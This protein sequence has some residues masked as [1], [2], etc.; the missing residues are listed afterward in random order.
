MILPT[1]WESI[2][3]QD[4]VYFQEGPGLRKWQF[5]DSGIP[6]LNIRTFNKGRI[7]KTKCQFVKLEE[8]T[9]KYEHFLLDAGD[10]VVSSS[11]TLGKLVVIKEQDLPL[12][13]NT[14]VIRY[15]S[16]YPEHLSQSFLKFYLQSEH[17]F[18]QIDTSKTGTAILNYGPS[19]LKQMRMLVP[20]SNEQ[21]R[22][23]AKLE[24]LFS[25]LDACR[26]RLEQVPR[27]LKQFRQSIL[28]AACSGKLTA[29]WRGGNPNVND[30]SSFPVVTAKIKAQF[31]LETFE[32]YQLPAT[33]SWKS[34]WQVAEIKSNLVNPTNFPKHLLIAPDNIEPES[35][36][37]V[38]VRTVAE[39]APISAKHFFNEGQI[40][41]SKI[42][43]Y[44][45]KL[46]VAEHD[47][48]CS[49]DMYPISAMINAHY[50]K[51]FM[52]SSYFVDKA[53]NIGTRT[54]L[55]KINQEELNSLPVAVPPI[56]EQE[57]IVRRVEALFKIADAVEDHYRK[58]QEQLDKL[59]QAILAKA[60]R[61]E[62]VPQDPKDEPASVLLE[63][64][65][66]EKSETVKPAKA[67]R[68]PASKAKKAAQG[69]LSY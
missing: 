36:R 5:G 11:G 46:I 51:W 40:V 20:P 59:P 64:I 41:Y 29:D 31:D 52:L 33:W 67:K 18:Q 54:L 17:F 34:F 53:S 61:G 68:Q 58:A 2:P 6:F 43:P 63:H 55:P 42:R 24:E 13:L 8:F 27:L 28:A 44:L 50:L 12:M 48:L 57:E 30:E 37:L 38:N 62:L 16:L 39:I 56:E 65:R 26:Q 47:G 10:I 4:C 32:K 49:A 45:S 69:E 15:R 1:G 21:R 66:A 9:G 25:R 60:F 22:I 14:S 7:D 19:H 23:A 3:I 35:S